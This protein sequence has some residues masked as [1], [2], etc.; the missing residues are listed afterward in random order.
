MGADQLYL[1]KR[2]FSSDANDAARHNSEAKFDVIV[3]PIMD[4]YALQ[5]VMAGTML[6]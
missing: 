3:F 6:N 1:S 2:Y 5:P 4:T